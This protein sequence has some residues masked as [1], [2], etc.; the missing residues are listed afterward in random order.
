MDQVAR[1]TGSIQSGRSVVRKDSI[2]GGIHINRKDDINS[3]GGTNQLDHLNVRDGVF[4]RAVLPKGG[5][6]VVEEVPLLN[7]RHY[8]FSGLKC[9]F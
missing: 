8:S 9:R 1:D 5:L 6:E 7:K 2:E 3:A 4:G